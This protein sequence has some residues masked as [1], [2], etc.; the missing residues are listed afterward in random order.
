VNSILDTGN[1]EEPELEGRPAGSSFSGRRTAARDLEP[2]AKDPEITLGTMTVL[3]IFFAL[4]VLCAGFFG[5]GYSVGSHR[6]ATSSTAPINGV[7]DNGSAPV[8]KPAPGVPVGSVAA[9]G[10]SSSAPVPTLKAAADD[11]A[12]PAATLTPTVVASR[13][14]RQPISPAD[15]EVVGDPAPA[16]TPAARL[17]VA[18]AAVAAPLAPAAPQTIVQVAALSHAEDAQIV[19]SALKSKG[20]DAAIHTSSQDK[21]LHVQ[22]GPFASRKDADSMRLRLLS[23]GFNAILK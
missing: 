6:A 9:A 21:L 13:N 11:A 4:A 14:S 2:E 1:E 22:I 5:F 15:G 20:Y 12:E 19:V 23:D 3:A 8:C 17:A 7:A 10:T 16:R 18:P